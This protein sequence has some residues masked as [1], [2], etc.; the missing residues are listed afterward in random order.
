MEVA[1]AGG[2]G[3]VWRGG[4]E[5]GWCGEYGPGPEGVQGVEGVKGAEGAE[6]GE[7]M[8]ERVGQVGGCMGV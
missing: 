4:E 3:G 1:G 6:R 8:G 2:W 7:C 5:R